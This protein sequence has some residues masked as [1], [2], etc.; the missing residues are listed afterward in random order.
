[1][2]A[3]TWGIVGAVAGVAAV[4]VALVQLR[5]SGA[6]ARRA[7]ISISLST[8]FPTVGGAVQDAQLGIEVIHRKG[9]PVTITNFG[10]TLSQSW[11]RGGSKSLNLTVGRPSF[12]SS[13]LPFRL[14]PGGE[15]ALFMVPYEALDDAAAKGYPRRR[16]R[17]WVRLGDGRKVYAKRLK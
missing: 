5:Q 14:V 2:A 4:V 1:M 17:P 9:A 13:P 16:M 11:R 6:S 7:G 10:V 8:C 3:E 15:P 12:A